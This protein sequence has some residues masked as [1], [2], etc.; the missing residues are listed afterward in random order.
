MSGICGWI[1]GLEREARAEQLVGAMCA[2]MKY[3]PNST[4]AAQRLGGA[5]IAVA[6]DAGATSILADGP[7]LAAIE[8]YPLWHDGE[9][10][11]VAR[12]HGHA[13]AL[14][15]GYKRL[16]RDLPKSVHG[17]AVFAVIDTANERGLVAIDR[18]GTRTMCYSTSGRE[19]VFGS[20]ADSVRVHP[21]S[22]SEINPQAIFSYLWFSKV[23]SPQTIYHDQRKL[24]PGQSI[25]FERGQVEVDRYWH[26]PY[27]VDG[28]RDA[29]RLGAE[30]LAV[31]RRSL[32]RALDGEA[33]QVGSFLSGGLDSSTVVGLMAER[34]AGPTHAFTIGFDEPGYDE[35]EYARISAKHFGAAHH[36]YYVTPDDV[37][38]AVP[39][40]SAGYD[41]PFGNASAVP[42]YYCAR[43]AQKHGIRLLMAGD[44]GDEL[45]GGNARYAKQKIFERYGIIPN[46]LRRG[47]IE[48]VVGNMP[49]RDAVLPLRKLWRYIEQAN[50]SLPFRMEAHN[51]YA[52]TSA[53]QIFLPDVAQ[54]IDEGHPRAVLEE[55]YHRTSSPDILHRMM[56]LDLQLVLADDDLRKVRRMCEIAGVAVKFPLLDDELVEFS[57]KVPPEL[58]ID[59]FK[60]RHFFKEACRGFLPEATL[61]KTKHGFGLPYGPWLRSGRLRAL[62]RDAIAS[63][64]SYRIFEP[65]FL[66]DAL[67]KHEVG[68]AAYHGAMVWDLMMLG[69]WL[70][71]HRRLG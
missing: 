26:V 29:E 4:A 64:K 36:E 20:S 60:L 58:L 32:E 63:L 40:I 68:H 17:H 3:G 48:P 54:A 12:T 21:A 51:L 27:A 2:A 35:M 11:E 69:S 31:A 13:A 6:G 47:L 52:G 9:L 65:E 50:I 15:R 67:K 39:I 18:V 71:A 22:A 7:F 59:G 56:H 70:N 23:P 44:G 28:S 30:M 10:V 53:R 46:W 37:A 61:T 19:L 49:L 33:G 45:F 14:I 24:M 8:G 42:V 43:L 66:D 1:G 57:A 62:A 34:S 25:W 55:V 16:G 5:A 38:E 41:E